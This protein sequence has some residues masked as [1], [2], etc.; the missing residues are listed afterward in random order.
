ML[1]K[2]ITLKQR[3]KIEKIKKEWEDEIDKIPENK[4]PQ[5]VFVLDGG[6]SGDYT[7]L[8]KKYLQMIQ[9]VLKES[10]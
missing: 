4:Y 6:N 10:E 7:K 8:S 3:E 9:E 1:E 2:N 5:G